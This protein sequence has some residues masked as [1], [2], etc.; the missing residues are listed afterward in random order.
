MQKLSDEDKKNKACWKG[1]GC[2]I[3]GCKF[4]HRALTPEEEEEKR[5]AKMS[6]KRRNPGRSP[7]APARGDGLCRDFQKGNCTRGKSCKFL[8]ELSNAAPAVGR[9]RSKS[10]GKNNGKKHKKDRKH[11]SKD[12]KHKKDRKDKKDRDRKGRH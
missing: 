8:R 9:S 5:K 11:K 10:S 3:P 4:Q 1:P 7:A 6:R 2:T 12:K